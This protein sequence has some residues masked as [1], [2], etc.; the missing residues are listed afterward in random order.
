V[1]PV[2]TKVD[3]PGADPELALRGLLQVAQQEGVTSAVSGGGGL[4]LPSHADGW[5]LWTSA[6]TG[7][8]TGEVLRAIAEMLPPPA[9]G[10]QAAA[11]NTN[12]GDGFVNVAVK[13]LKTDNARTSAVSVESNSNSDGSEVTPS[14]LEGFL[15]SAA[16]R[17]RTGEGTGWGSGR[18]DAPLRAFLFDSWHDPHRGS[19]AVVQVRDGTLTRGASVQLASTGRKYRI[20]D[21]GVLSPRPLR[22]EGLPAGTVGWFSAGIRDARECRVGDTLL[23]DP[24]RPSVRPSQGDPPM[25]PLPGFAPASP[26][27]FASVYPSDGGDFEAL[28]AAVSRLQLTDASLEAIKE[29]SSSLGSG[30]R[31]GFLGLLHMDVVQER[32][33][34]EHGQEV[35]VT[36]PMAPLLVVLKDGSA[37]AKARRLDYERELRA[38]GVD[39]KAVRSAMGEAEDGSGFGALEALDL[40]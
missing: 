30:F 27:V 14:G 5:C 9:P 36:A 31:C 3:L 21:L 10:R 19:V 38:A 1:L 25:V 11:G 40:P 33:R 39:L 2:L 6:K 4:L 16:R 7:E 32:L 8:G 18:P 23:D 24:D 12:R 26:M 29:R 34:Q 28:D 13:G 35:V 37:G 20:Q 22:A 17:A 15:L